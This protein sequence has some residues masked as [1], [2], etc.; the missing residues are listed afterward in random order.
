MNKRFVAHDTFIIERTYK[1]SPAKVFAAWS[2]PSFKSRWFSKPDQFD[3]RVGGYE[4]SR[5]GPEG[6]PVYSF[7]A[8]YQEIIPEQRIVY[9]YTM[10]LN[11]TRISASVTT[12]EF[13]PSGTGTQ[14][15]FTEQG[16]FFDG[17]D[18]SEQREHGTRYMLDK[19][20]EELE[21]E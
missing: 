19:L 14:L 16:A 11:D 21:A 13:K 9:T 10:D 18:S 5:G 4:R 6:G 20:G 7:D 15:I 12:V 3:F 8:C 1:A 17:H 2:D